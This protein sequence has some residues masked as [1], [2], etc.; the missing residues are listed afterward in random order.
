MT[1]REKFNYKK[2]GIKYIYHKQV[3]VLFKKMII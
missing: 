2:G 1:S 3:H